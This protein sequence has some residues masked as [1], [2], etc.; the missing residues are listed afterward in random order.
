[1]RF[2]PGCP[3]WKSIRIRFCN[4]LGI[5]TLSLY[6]KMLLHEYTSETPLSFDAIFCFISLIKSSSIALLFI[7]DSVTGRSQIVFSMMDLISQSDQSAAM[8]ESSSG[9]H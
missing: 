9:W 7:S 2:F 5:T 3:V 6:N 1:M 4:F 8:T